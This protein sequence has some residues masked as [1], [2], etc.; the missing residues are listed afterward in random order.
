MTTFPHTFL[1]LGA[2]IL[3]FILSIDFE[4][5]FE[6]GIFPQIFK[7]AKVIPIHKSGNKQLVQ[8]YRPI[9]LLPCVSKI[10]EKLI[11]NRLITFF[12]KT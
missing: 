6:F 3:A 5:V 10:L 2:E 7:T 8:N 11:K 9:S 12:F 4:L 1:R